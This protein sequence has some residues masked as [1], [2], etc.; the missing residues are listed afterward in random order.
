MWIP[1]TE[2]EIVNAVTSGA[3]EESAIFDA[4]KEL[5][6]KNQ[7]IAKD[8]AAMANDGGVLI[9]GIGEDAHDQPTILNPI[10]LTGQPERVT[11]IVQ[12]SIAEPPA[13]VISMIQTAAD[14]SKGY[15]IVVVPASERAPHMVVVKGEYRYYGRTAT[16]NTPLTEAEVAR[17]YERRQRWEVD[18][19]SLLAKEIGQS[20]FS[21]HADFAYLYLIARPVLQNEGL[22]DQAVRTGQTIQGVLHDLV[23]LVRGHNIFPQGYEPDF[24]TPR[25]WIQRAEGFLGKLYFPDPSNPGEALNL[26]IDLD[27]SAH[28]FCGRAAERQGERF[29]FF[30]FIVAG[31]TTKFIALLGEIYT[32]ANYIGM[33]DIGVAITGIKGSSF[34]GGS[35]RPLSPYDRDEY[36][37]T[38]RI[39][40]LILKDDPYGPAKKLLMPLFNAISQG[41]L[42]PFPKKSPS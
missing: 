25:R 27:G 33:V 40:A 6:S 10:P 28:L 29:E 38:E 4:K 3:L 37:R 34:I 16:G 13:I 5:P 8:I 2:D 24:D 35:G 12:T 23:T 17:L 7:E 39:S 41:Y 42:N 9:Y 36:R 20:P 18:W 21:P 14:P 15:L 32:R 11:S 26:Q 22:L 30:P 1:K 19:E 31:N